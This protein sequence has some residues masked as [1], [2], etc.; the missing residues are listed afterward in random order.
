MNYYT[1]VFY[2]ILGVLLGLAGV[3]VLEQPGY[4]LGIMACVMAIHLLS[5]QG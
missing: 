5:R 3:G 4:F 1:L 2:A